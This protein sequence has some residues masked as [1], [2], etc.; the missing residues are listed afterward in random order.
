M[1]VGL[2]SVCRVEGFRVRVYVHQQVLG[3]AVGRLS[4]AERELL[5]A[6]R[7]HS[8]LQASP[9]HLASAAGCAGTLLSQRHSCRLRPDA[10]VVAPVRRLHAP[11]CRLQAQQPAGA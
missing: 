5:M 11:A 9:G 7:K 4:N 8:T 2:W 6:A 3:A 10:C 1:V